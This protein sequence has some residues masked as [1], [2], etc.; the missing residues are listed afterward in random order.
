MA[1]TPVGM[2]SAI[3]ASERLQ[4]YSLDRATSGIGKNSILKMHIILQIFKT[5]PEFYGNREFLSY[6]Q[7]FRNSSFSLAK[8]IQ[9]TLCHPISLTPF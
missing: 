1:M 3:P 4:T 9:S 6:F 5:F 8:L 2:E 7:R